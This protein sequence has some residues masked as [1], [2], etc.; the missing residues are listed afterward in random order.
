MK[1]AP[2]VNAAASRRSW[3][4]AGAVRLGGEDVRRIDPQ[5]LRRQIAVV[6]QQPALFSADVMHNIRYGN[7]EASDADV[8]A[9][10][11]DAYADEFIERLPEGYASFLGERGVRLSGGQK[12]RIALARCLLKDSP[13]LILDDPISQVDLETGTN[14]I[15]AIRDLAASKTIVIVSHR[16]SAVSYANHIIT[17]DRGRMVESGS[18]QELM[19]TNNYYAKTFRLQEFEEDLN[20]S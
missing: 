7:P 11:A 10:A 19:Q 16:L 20:A 14:I 18:H 5:D 15:K 9:A 1:V 6:A 2:A 3:P 13:I 4:A 12:Q 17:L 8:F